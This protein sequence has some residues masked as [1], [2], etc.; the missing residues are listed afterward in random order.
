MTKRTRHAMGLGLILSIVG[1]LVSLFGWFVLKLTYAIG[2]SGNTDHRPLTYQ[3]IGVGIVLILVGI[4]SI[5]VGW[6][7]SPR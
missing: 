4:V 2:L 6:L 7:R 5:L 3:I 1:A